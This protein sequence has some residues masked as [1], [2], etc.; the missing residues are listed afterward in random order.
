MKDTA[1]KQKQEMVELMLQILAI[2]N[3]RNL[4]KSR[5][6]SCTGTWTKSNEAKKQYWSQTHKNEKCTILNTVPKPTDDKRKKGEGRRRAKRKN[7]ATCA[8]RSNGTRGL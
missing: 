4:S 2:S 3:R 5:V 6:E 1:E 8:R 7:E